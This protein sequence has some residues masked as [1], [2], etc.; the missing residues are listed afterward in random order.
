MASTAGVEI[1]SW[2]VSPS[3]RYQVGLRT[4]PE[5]LSGTGKEF[6]SFILTGLHSLLYTGPPPLITALV[7][8]EVTVRVREF[9]EEEITEP[10]V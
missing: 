7:R 1:L 9:A 8:G 10:C 5:P 4:G 3:A 2:K 6:V